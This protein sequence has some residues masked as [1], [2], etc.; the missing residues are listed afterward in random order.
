MGDGQGPKRPVS[1]GRWIRQ[2]QA[3]ESKRPDVSKTRR[4]SLGRGYRLVLYRK[5]LFGRLRGA[6]FFKK[7]D[8]FASNS[9]S[10]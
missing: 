4:A 2:N 7:G 1:P 10:V 3:P 9:L 8:F 5:C 6:V